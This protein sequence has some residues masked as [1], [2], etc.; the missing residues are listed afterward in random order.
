MPRI[1]GTEQSKCSF[2]ISLPILTNLSICDQAELN[3]KNKLKGIRKESPTD[4]ESWCT[5]SSGKGTKSPCRNGGELPQAPSR[6]PAGFAA[7]PPPATT[8]WK[9]LLKPWSVEAFLSRSKGKLRTLKGDQWLLLRQLM[10]FLLP[11]IDVGPTNM[12]RQAETANRRA[13]RFEFC[14]TLLPCSSNSH[15]T[16]W[17]LHK[18]V[19][20]ILIATSSSK[21][22]IA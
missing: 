2:L 6:A 3:Q 14:M 18:L 12:I 16:C 7:A 22:P 13:Y 1:P 21:Y 20:D 10:F 8:P 11:A 19:G 17:D 15:R 9:Q 4:S 5:K